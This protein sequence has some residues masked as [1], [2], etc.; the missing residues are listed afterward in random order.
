[1]A[2]GIRC[3]SRLQGGGKKQNK[4]KPEANKLK[5]AIRLWRKAAFFFLTDCALF[6][7]PRVNRAMA[8]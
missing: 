3:P 2:A 6:G 7:W 5:Q 8:E 1:M 4:A